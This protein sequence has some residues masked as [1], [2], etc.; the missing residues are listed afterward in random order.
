MASAHVLPDGIARIFHFS[1]AASVFAFILLLV[2][3][4]P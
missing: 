2:A 3:L 1:L 4:H